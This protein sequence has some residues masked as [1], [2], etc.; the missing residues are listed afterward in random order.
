MHSVIQKAMGIGKT[1]EHSGIVKKLADDSIIVSIVK[2]TGCVS[3]QAKESCNLSETEEKEIEVKQNSSSSSVGEKVLVYYN[4]SLGFR[5]LFL[6]YVLPFII[7]LLVL[8]TLSLIGLSESVAGLISLG[9]LLPYFLLLYFTKNKQKKTFSF[10][11]K[12]I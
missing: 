11:I 5:A 2:N 12:K 6:A 8:I 10:S 4:Q 7:V 3:C 1:I 9:S